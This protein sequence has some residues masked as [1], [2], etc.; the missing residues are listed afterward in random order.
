MVKARFRGIRTRILVIALVPSLV[1]I[2]LGVGTSIYLFNDGRHAEDFARTLDTHLTPTREL[3]LAVEQERLLSVSQ[4][5]GGV[6][7]PG[8]LVTARIRFDSALKSLAV[9]EVA[10]QRVGGSAMGNTVAAFDE[11]KARLPELRSAIDSGRLPIADAYD[12]YSRLLD[13]MD[14][15]SATIG[16][17]APD[18]ASGADL[19]RNMGL[20]HV[21]ESMSRASALTT[22]VVHPQNVSPT[23]F[24]EYRN[25]VSYYHVEIAR[26]ATV[27]DAANA[28]RIKDLTASPAW[29]QVSAMESAIVEARPVGAPQLPMS[30]AE[31]RAAADEVSQQLV[32]LWV[33]HAKQAQQYAADAGARHARNSLLAAGVLG[34]VAVLAFLLSL[35]LANQLIGR[36]KR[37]HSE[38]LAVAEVRLPQTLRRLNEGV[39]IDPETEAAQLDFGNDEIGQVAQAFNRAHGAAVAAA[40]TEANTREGVRAVFSNIAHRSQIVVHR[41]LEILDAAERRQEDPALLETLFQLDHLATRGRR[42]AENLIILGGGRPGRQWRRPVPLGELVRGAIAETVQYARVFTG[43]G[44]PSV[45]VNGAVVADLIHLLAELVDNAT[46]FSPPQSR[47]DVTGNLIGT[48]VVVAIS[49]QGM[50]MSDSELERANEVLAAPPDFSVATLSS[51]SRLGLFVVARL[52]IR[53]GISVRLT[54]S[55]YGGVRAVVVI[56]TA[57]LAAENAGIAA[58]TAVQ[59]W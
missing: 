54:E 59:R 19:A 1:L 10:L 26:L 23:L 25:L 6:I 42:N 7:D 13:G 27:L 5:A 45:F 33:G 14:Q 29:Q 9:T 4:L 46:A 36:L 55:D 56:P 24:A 8:A 51:D 16:Q 28:Q 57:V 34:A 52:G 17:F 53:H 18:A 47:V 50:G 43:A 31:W 3:V 15:G 48:G 2:C 30:V 12:F 37:L 39:R 58:P 49:D 32:T 41:Q 11:L 35:W 38:T 44:L 22:A 40:V 20:L 21:V